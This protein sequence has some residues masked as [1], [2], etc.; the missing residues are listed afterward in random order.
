[1]LLY[2]WVTLFLTPDLI[3]ERIVNKVND[4]FTEVVVLSGFLCVFCPLSNSMLSVF[5][6]AICVCST[7]NSDKCPVIGRTMTAYFQDKRKH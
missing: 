2:H 7:T 3:M 1:M 4:P 6:A 5:H